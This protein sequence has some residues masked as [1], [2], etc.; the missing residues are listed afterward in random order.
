MLL[1]LLLLL[2]LYELP[3][4]DSGIRAPWADP[5]DPDRPTSTDLVSPSRSLS[6]P[7]RPES[8]R[9]ARP[10]RFERQKS[11]ENV[12][13]AAS[14]RD[15]RRFWVDLGTDFRGFSRLHRASDS[16]RS[17]K[18]RTSVFTGRRGTFKGSQ[19][20]PKKRKSTKIDEKSLRRCFANELHEENSIFPLPDATWRRF[21]SSQCAPECS[22]AP[23]LTFRG[24]LR[25]SLGAPGARRGRP[26]TLPRRSR[27]AFGT[28]LDA[29]GCPERV[30]GAIFTRFWVPRAVSG[31]RFSIDFLYDFRSILRA[32]WPA[33]GKT[34]DG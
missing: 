24:A 1:S 11:T 4:G 20:L 21:W 13:R 12:A 32:S 30:P 28:L 19:T 7:K 31:D 14:R 16:T 34:L 6:R 10:G 2:S 5:T 3:P 29:S 8:L 15:F 18:S 23:F 17:A 25:D 27:D 26:K 22:R 9:V 33:N